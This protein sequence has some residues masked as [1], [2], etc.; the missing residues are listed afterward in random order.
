MPA[1]ELGSISL[2][3]CRRFDAEETR[4]YFSRFP[5]VPLMRARHLRRAQERIA[6][7]G[8]VDARVTANARLTL[9]R[10]DVS[11]HGTLAR[12][13]VRRRQV[14][15]LANCIHIGLNQHFGIRSSVREVASA[16]TLGCDRSV[17]INEGS[18]RRRVAFGAHPK[19][20]FGRGQRILS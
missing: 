15:M 3:Q 4:P 9:R 11:R 17:L 2:G 12:C 16:A 18:G 14:A 1:T 6:G 7:V 8:A 20:P 19:L 5:S 13:G 10:L